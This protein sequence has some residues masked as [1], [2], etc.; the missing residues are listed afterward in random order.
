MEDIVSYLDHK[1]SK[2]SLDEI[3]IEWYKC[4]INPF[5]F[6]FN[7][8][9]IPEIGGVLKYDNTKMHYKIKRV[10]KS[11]FR[12]HKVLFMATRQMGKALDIETK[13]PIDLNGNYK[14]MKDIHIGDTVLDEFSKPT[15]VV[16]ETNIM[17]DR[18]CYDLIIDDNVQITCDENHLWK[19]FNLEF[20]NELLLTTKQIYN[21]F[22]TSSQNKLFIRKSNLN[23][24]YQTYYTITSIAKRI[25]SVP[26]K[27]IQVE[28]FSGMY[29]CTE[30]NVP[31]HNSTIAACLLEWVC[32]FFPRVPA[33]ILN[34]NK[35]FALENL[36]KV[37][38]IHQNI[39]SAL[40]TPLKNKGERK[41]FL[42]YMNGSILRVFYPSS[43]TSP[44]TLARSLTSPI[45]YIDECAYIRHMKTAYS[46]AQPTLSRAREQAKKNK[47]PYFIFLTSTPNGVVGDGQWFYE[48]YNY[49]VDSDEIFDDDNNFIDEA[50]SLVNN[51]ER[52]GFIRVKFHWS[53]DSEKD[54][55]W[56]KEQCRDLNFDTRSI[57]QELDLVFVGSTNC[58][59][60][61]EFLSQLRH[62]KP[63]NII[64]LPHSC[65][66]RLFTEIFNSNDYYL[67]GVDSAKSITGDYNA[68]EIFS[69]D[70]FIQVGEFF[71]KLGS[72][73]KYSQ[74]LMEIVKFLNSFI[75]DRI[76]LCI[77]N[78]SIGSAIIEA[79]E[80]EESYDFLQYV[81][82]PTPLVN[83][84][85][86]GNIVRVPKHPSQYGINTNSSTKSKMISYVYEFFTKNPKCIKSIDLIN[87]LNVIE[88]TANGSI[89]AQYPYHDDIFMA[90]ALCA[91][92]RK[93]SSLEYEPLIKS[94]EF[95]EYKNENLVT[96]DIIISNKNSN[97]YVSM[98]YN[99][100]DQGYE[101]ILDEEIEDNLEDNFTFSIF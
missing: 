4:K 19:V 3:S 98:K 6:I 69:Y 74:I 26:V 83:K 31:T 59:F 95:E 29:L 48:M 51:P 50:D 81:Y 5:Y 49:S 96:S 47:Y 86:Q 101:Y 67:I 93:I 75:G 20:Q 60:S 88:R 13:I 12:Y 33:T 54:E 42:E 84:M 41:T 27:C 44:S 57:N 23:N 18:P 70:N 94:D 77:E 22:I 46:S 2:M 73:T 61:D 36:E 34:A 53:E 80:N 58:I 17:Y 7:Y 40:R 10:V 76:I 11:V 91:Y 90:S 72:L 66:L 30:Y 99:K 71:G 52:N 39:P 78:N 85:K 15:K 35:S 65:H 82:T 97:Q 24:N 63:S 14:L 45:L 1:L 92:V 62:Q 55:N 43:T 28:N 68:I 8:V 89:R 32:N 100:E 16:A 9:F 87:Q 38:L 25:N 56:Y 21:N 79:L 37:K 64:T